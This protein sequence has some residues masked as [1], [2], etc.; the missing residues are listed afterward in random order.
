MTTLY[1]KGSQYHKRFGGVMYD[2]DII[3]TKD[4][5]EITKLLK[6]EWCESLPETVK[7]KPK[8]K[9]KGKAGADK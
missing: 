4:D 6:G 1:K 9:A 3:K 2:F 7:A 8:A 5:N